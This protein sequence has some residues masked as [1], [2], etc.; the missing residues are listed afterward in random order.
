MAI[1]SPAVDVVELHLDIGVCRNCSPMHRFSSPH[2]GLLFSSLTWTY[3]SFTSPHMLIVHHHDGQN[4]SS[5]AV[6]TAEEGLDAGLPVS[7]PYYDSCWEGWKAAG[8]GMVG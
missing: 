4:I 7:A 2:H 8:K 3:G 5:M 1:M 6:A